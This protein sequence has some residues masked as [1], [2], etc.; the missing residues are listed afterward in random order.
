MAIQWIRNTRYTDSSC[1]EL[2]YPQDFLFPEKEVLPLSPTWQCM[3]QW[4]RQ[5][6]RWWWKGG[7]GDEEEEEKE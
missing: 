7:G 2:L 3:R 1:T 5:C 4:R 6:L